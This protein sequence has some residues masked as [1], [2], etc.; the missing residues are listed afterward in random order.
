MRESGKPR[1][2][3]SLHFSF[4]LRNGYQIRVIIALGYMINV[5]CTERRMYGRLQLS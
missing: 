1:M 4:N 3:D 2:E 5:L